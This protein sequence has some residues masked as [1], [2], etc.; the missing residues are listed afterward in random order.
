MQILELIKD[1]GNHKNS[2]MELLSFDGKKVSMTRQELKEL[3]INKGI[4]V[5]NMELSKSG[6]LV[7]V[8]KRVAWLYINLISYD[9]SNGICEV[10]INTDNKDLVNQFM[11]NLERGILFAGDIVY[12]NESCEYQVNKNSKTGELSIIIRWIHI[13]KLVTALYDVPHVFKP[14]HLL[15]MRNTENFAYMSDEQFGNLVDYLTRSL[16]SK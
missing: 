13:D 4:M 14:G 7:K 3:L 11:T 12:T 10:E 1:G 16:N 6:R 2:V 15:N 9:V 5:T 8:D